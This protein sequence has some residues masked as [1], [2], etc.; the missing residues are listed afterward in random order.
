MKNKDWFRIFVV[1]YKSSK[2][3]GQKLTVIAYTVLFFFQVRRILSTPELALLCFNED[4][5]TLNFAGAAAT[6]QGTPQGG[7]KAGR[8]FRVRPTLISHIELKL[9]TFLSSRPGVVRTAGAG[10]PRAGGRRLCSSRLYRDWD[11]ETKKK[12]TQK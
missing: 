5:V 1:N 12:R 10:R 11:K 9:F 2:V 4:L 7:R 3:C 6:A 8:L